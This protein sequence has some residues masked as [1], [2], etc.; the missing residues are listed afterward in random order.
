LL[1]IN[2]YGLSGLTP[3]TQEILDTL[4]EREWSNEVKNT[5]QP[6]ENLA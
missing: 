4:I 2:I 6:K 5:N 3:T 1:P